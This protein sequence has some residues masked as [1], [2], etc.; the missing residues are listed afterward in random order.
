M[1]GMGLNKYVNKWK[2]TARL[3]KESQTIRKAKINTCC[4]IRIRDYQYE[5]IVFNI[6]STQIHK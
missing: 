3:V 6:Y 5:L 4:W 1:Y 2:M